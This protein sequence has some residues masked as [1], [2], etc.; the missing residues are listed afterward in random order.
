MRFGVIWGRIS[1]GLTVNRYYTYWHYNA[2]QV[3]L[4]VQLLPVSLFFWSKDMGWRWGWMRI[5]ADWWWVRW[6]SNAASLCSALEILDLDMMP[7][8]IVECPD[9]HQSLAFHCNYVYQDVLWVCAIVT[10]V[11]NQH[12]HAWKGLNLSY[13]PYTHLKG[14]IWCY[15]CYWFM[16]DINRILTRKTQNKQSVFIWLLFSQ[17]NFIKY[18]IWRAFY[19]ASLYNSLQIF[20]NQLYLS[21]KRENKSNF[22]TLSSTCQ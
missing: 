7:G 4:F 17:F 12:R 15:L 18:L 11:Q 20:F 14:L 22:S 6:F 3:L 19:V 2:T 13:L 5:N 9:R 1:L 8:R 16:W 10:D 21:K